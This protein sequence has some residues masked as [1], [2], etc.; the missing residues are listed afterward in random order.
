MYIYK[1]GVNS[2]KFVEK[3]TNMVFSE[4]P[5]GFNS[6]ATE[7]N[8]LVNPNAAFWVQLNYN[9]S[10]RLLGITLRYVVGNTNPHNCS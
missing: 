3:L 5:E 2:E 4:T 1:E 10:T 8:V 7:I 9:Q 6:L